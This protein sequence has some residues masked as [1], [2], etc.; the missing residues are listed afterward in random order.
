MHN[1]IHR[2]SAA[3]QHAIVDKVISL[4]ED[5]IREQ[6]RDTSDIVRPYCAADFLPVTESA[7]KRRALSAMP[8][9]QLLALPMCYTP[10]SL[11]GRIITA[12][13]MAA[14]AAAA[15]R[16]AAAAES[17]Q[18]RPDLKQPYRNKRACVGVVVAL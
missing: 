4:T 2:I 1:R 5:Q 17:L 14:V 11:C 6:M 18:A 7:I 10:E 12:R 16:S 9:E 3:V 13:Y 15:Q 8:I